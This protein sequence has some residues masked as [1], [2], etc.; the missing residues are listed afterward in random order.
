[1]SIIPVAW[2]TYYWTDYVGQAHVIAG[3][4]TTEEQARRYIPQTPEAQEAFT[5][6]LAISSDLMWVLE[7]TFLTLERPEAGHG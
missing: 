2:K 6:L 1:M 3:A 5:K 4:P 7:T